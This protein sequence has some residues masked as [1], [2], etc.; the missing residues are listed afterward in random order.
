MLC[1]DQLHRRDLRHEEVGGDGVGV[2]AQEHQHLPLH[3]RDP[4]QG[5]PGAGLLRKLQ[6]TLQHHI[7][8]DT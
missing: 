2:R 7:C 8:Q 1:V 5:A 6:Q 3:L 4:V